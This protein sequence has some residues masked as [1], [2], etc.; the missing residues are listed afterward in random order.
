MIDIDLE[1]LGVGDLAL[2]IRVYK[3]AFALAPFGVSAN[4]QTRLA[5]ANGLIFSSQRLLDSRFLPFSRRFPDL[6]FDL[7]YR[8]KP[9]SDSHLL[10]A[11]LQSLQSTTKMHQVSAL[12]L[13]DASF[14][15]LQKR[16]FL[17]LLL[18]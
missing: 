7:R 11:W 2:S 3:T 10:Y 14:T 16:G 6:S 1:V 12:T 5:V 4:S 13:P 15:F 9:W 17:S 8:L 18:P